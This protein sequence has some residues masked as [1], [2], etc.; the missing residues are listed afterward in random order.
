MFES[1]AG[2]LCI[3]HDQGTDVV[4]LEFA[5]YDR[6]GDFTFFDVGEDIDVQEE[7]VGE[8]DQAFDAAVEEHFK[9]TFEAAAFVVNVGENGKERR[10]VESVLHA[11]Q[12]K[13]A[14]RV[15]HVED[16][17]PNG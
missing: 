15:S 4:V 9:I 16:H 10:L 11:A 3:V 14:V 7:P 17:D 13:S 8:H 6:R 12:Y 1:G 2:A 5:S